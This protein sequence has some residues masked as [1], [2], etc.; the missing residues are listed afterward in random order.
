M[1]MILKIS[2]MLGEMIAVDAE[3]YL[4]VERPRFF[5]LMKVL[6]SPVKKFSLRKFT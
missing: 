3:P 1:A 2:S 5:K 6:E 4:I